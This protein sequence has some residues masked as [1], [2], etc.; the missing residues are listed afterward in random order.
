MG[1]KDTGK[2]GE[3]STAK[4]KAKQHGATNAT[5]SRAESN[6]TFYTAT[7]KENVV[8]SARALSYYKREQR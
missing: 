7:S 6:K 2:H 4:R 3:S 1:A 8:C 5:H